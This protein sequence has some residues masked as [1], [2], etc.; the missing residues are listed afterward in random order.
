[1][2]V[3]GLFIDGFGHFHH[4]ELGPF[5][6][7]LVVL[8]GPN[9]AGKSTL[10]AFLLYV[11]FG[12][13]RGDPSVALD[14]GRLGGR[15]TFVV[16]DDT[17]VVERLDKAN[18]VVRVSAGAAFHA[19]TVEEVLGGIDRALFR[20]IYS[21]SLDDLSSF[22]KL[23]TDE[24][25]DRLFTG[26]LAG[27]GRSVSEAV[28][29]LDRRVEKLWMPRGACII[30]E[31]KSQ[32]NSVE[33][34]LDAVR[35]QA[36]DIGRK[37]REIEDADREH[38]EQ[39]ALVVSAS[40]EASRW[41]AMIAAFP[42]EEKRQREKAK[43]ELLPKGLAI[44][45][46][47]LLQADKLAGELADARVRLELAQQ[48]VQRKNSEIARVPSM[49]GLVEY[50]LELEA[51][52]QR[53]SAVTPQ[54][55][56]DRADA[57]Q[58]AKDR[59]SK[60]L[61][62]VG[63][64]DLEELDRLDLSA[65][66]LESLRLL[67]SAAVLQRKRLEQAEEQHHCREKLVAKRDRL[68]TAVLN[69]P[70]DPVALDVVRAVETL[71]RD[72]LTMQS[73]KNNAGALSLKYENTVAEAKHLKAEL[74]PQALEASTDLIARGHLAAETR[75]FQSEV[76]ASDARHAHATAQ[77]ELRT[78]ALQ[79]ACT[80][81]DGLP[82]VVDAVPPAV[83]NVVHGLDG[84]LSAHQQALDAAERGKLA[85]RDFQEILAQL[86]KPWTDNTIECAHV[87]S[88]TLENLRSASMAHNG[89]V[90]AATSKTTEVEAFLEEV[91]QMGIDPRAPGP[92]IAEVKD[93]LD[94]IEDAENAIRESR[95]EQ[96]EQGGAIAA[97]FP[98]WPLVL[99]VILGVILTIVGSGGLATG[100][101]TIGAVV[102]ALGVLVL[103]IA[104]GGFVKRPVAAPAHGLLPPVSVKDISGILGKIGLSASAGLADIQRLRREAQRANNIAA[105]QERLARLECQ[106]ADIQ[107]AVEQTHY[108]WIER[109]NTASWPATVLPEHF[110]RTLIPVLRARDRLTEWR[111]EV[112]RETLGNGGFEAWR[113]LATQAAQVLHQTPPY[114][115]P[116]ARQFVEDI[117]KSQRAAED[118]QRQRRDAVQRKVEADRAITEAKELVLDSNRVAAA[119]S[120]RHAALRDQATKLGVP[121]DL[122]LDV[123]STWLG[124]AARLREMIKTAK[125][126]KTEVAR[127]EGNVAVWNGRFNE[128]VQIVLGLIGDEALE[129]A[130]QRCN[131]A[132]VLQQ[133]VSEAEVRAKNAQEALDEHDADQ[134]QSQAVLVAHADDETAWKRALQDAH[135]PPTVA[136]ATLDKF[137]DVARRA[138]EAALEWNTADQVHRLIQEAALS[139][140]GDVAAIAKDVGEVAPKDLGSARTWLQAAFARVA[141]ERKVGEQADQL[142][143]ALTLAQKNELDQVRI[144][145]D[146]YSRLLAV[147]ER[148]AV[149]SLETLKRSAQEHQI[150]TQ[151]AAQIKAAQEARD[152]ALGRDATDPSVLLLFE[153]TDEAMWTADAESADMKSQTAKDAAD[154]ALQRRTTLDIEVQALHGSKAI[155]DLDVERASIITQ[156]SI[157]R[158]EL[159]R[160]LLSKALLERT[161][162]RFREAHQPQIL[163]TASGYLST[164]TGGAYVGI[165]TDDDGKYLVLVDRSGGRRNSGDL[166]RGTAEA[167]YL[168]L[169]LSLARATT[170]RD[171]ALPLLLDDV[172]VNLD[173]CRATAM[174]DLLGE[175]AQDRQV[176]LLTCRP[177]I[178]DLLAERVQETQVIEL[179]RFAGRNGPI[180]GTSL[181]RAPLTEIQERA[182]PRNGRTASEAVLG[183]LSEA[184]EPLGKEDIKR[185]AGISETEWT[186]TIGQ[187]KVSGR[188]LQTGQKRGAKYQ[189]RE[190]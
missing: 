17:V 83:T 28:A 171:L 113:Q 16:G 80:L 177:E 72:K 36:D 151:V 18:P 163:R 63:F 148:F 49:S 135:L 104:L 51:L 187:L 182:E 23:G 176:L 27:A 168:V 153:T 100:A 38:R 88:G 2:A 118:R 186:A 4:Y 81:L 188:V 50:A 99:A 92:S 35:R 87:D 141:E 59:L 115:A 21:F 15:L 11:L 1:M 56:H 77:V 7:G 189:I 12:P 25:R 13:R 120:I 55:I 137:L 29:R 178:R 154:Q 124:D 24:L 147:L 116:T 155:A 65:S 106:R 119:L 37:I 181:K 32:L 60:V 64:A 101:A 110:E 184:I 185:Q 79:D 127:L 14:G 31:L 157:A 134:A 180:A 145:E 6:P 129:L 34:G 68:A 57:V 123:A 125:E 156:L 19:T 136:A 54:T 73:A 146:L 26:S 91:R 170:G 111:S 67:A 114:D 142:K 43:G 131:K 108:Q 42:H 140:I 61:L 112:E 52:G 169:R 98:R 30:R 95:I 162:K 39:T 164:V 9:E 158:S 107:R 150:Y 133:K 74:G 103:M 179:E 86:G 94:L 161:L 78:K 165:E 159:A 121:V 82:E 190:K 46:P 33:Q 8:H 53:A 160:L 20:A 144:V 139:F 143:A 172:L 174:A 70:R 10:S 75:V 5:E 48:D 97:P 22:E 84:A 183:V 93:H 45:P 47:Q 173:P 128:V 132:E 105:M 76:A 62:E 130:T 175:V 167:L 85:W 138:R 3:R 96:T 90:S 149:E 122:D 117:R 69:L 41:R 89:A 166:S 40:R 126:M 66:R 58:A 44:P 102:V 71:V 109:L 152:A